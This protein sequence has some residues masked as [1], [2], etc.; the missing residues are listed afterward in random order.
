MLYRLGHFCIRHRFAVAAAWVV[1]AIVLTIVAKSAGEQTSNNL[2]LPGTE[3]TQATD[4]L[5]QYLPHEANGTNPVALRA[6]SGK[7]TDSKNSKVVSRDRALARGG[8]RGR[9]ARSAR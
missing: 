7:L 8:A 2:T 4:L 3:S 5:D 9:A 1:I 6:P